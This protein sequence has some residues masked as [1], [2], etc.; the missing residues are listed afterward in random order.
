MNGHLVFN[1]N[2]LPSALLETL[3]SGQWLILSFNLCYEI[4]SSLSSLMVVVV[5]ELLHRQR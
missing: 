5:S 4:S 2:I 1:N 3:T